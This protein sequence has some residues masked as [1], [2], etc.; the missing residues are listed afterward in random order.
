[1][2]RKI[3]IGQCG[4]T[5]TVPQPPPPTQT[6]LFVI[7][8]TANPA[9]ILLPELVFNG[10]GGSTAPASPMSSNTDSGCVAS[11]P[12]SGSQE[13]A[14]RSFNSNLGDSA[15]LSFASSTNA[16]Q[17]VVASPIVVRSLTI[18]K[19]TGQVYYYMPTAFSLYENGVLLGSWTTTWPTNHSAS[20]QTFFI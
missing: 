18:S 2:N 19:A 13:T 17:L 4:G 20:S 16:I 11:I 8:G 6:L 12:N 7:T 10:D 15:S 3:L 1:M 5:A 14:Y 9:A